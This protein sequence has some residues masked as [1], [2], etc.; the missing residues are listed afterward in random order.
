MNNS[1]SICD[2]CGETHYET[3]WVINGF[4]IMQC[5]NC[6]LVFANVSESDTKNIYEKD[7]YTE[8]YPDY[9]SD[10]NVHDITNLSL[11]R[12]IEKFFSPGSMIEI[13]SAF[14]FF[15]GVASKRGWKFTG[16]ET[17]EYASSLARAKNHQNVLC[18]D[19]MAA[20]IG[21]D[22][23]V[24]CM[25]DT[26]EHLIKPSLY[27]EKIAGVLKKGGGLAITTG[28]FSS[29][30][31]RI[32]GKKWRMIAPPLHVYYYTQ[33]TLCNLLTQNGFKILSITHPSKYQNLNSMF[34]YQFGISKTRLPKLPVKLNLGDIMLV[35]AE[36][37]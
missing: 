15:A 26:I 2:I 5:S 21:T 13:G 32:Q 16:Y 19:F 29:L 18:E 11:I 9:E 37:E 22:L 12:E 34:H 4:N 35:I 27:I 10:R 25:F 6:G 17:S 30:V 33:K 8:V 1:T 24:V 14:G 3:L 23:D 36:K 20:D 7:Y 28:D 31:A